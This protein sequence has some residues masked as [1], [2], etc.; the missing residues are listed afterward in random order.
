MV[1]EGLLIMTLKSMAKT[2]ISLILAGI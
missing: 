2:R 1:G